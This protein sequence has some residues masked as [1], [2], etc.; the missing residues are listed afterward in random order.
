VDQGK[1][2][3]H[4]SYWWSPDS[5]WLVFNRNGDDRR[6]R[7]WLYNLANKQV[8]AVTDGWYDSY[9]ASFS[10]DGKYLVFVSDRDFNPIYS[11]TEWNHAYADM[12]KIY[13]V[14][15]AKDT[16]S[17][18]QL[19]N[20][21][22]KSVEPKTETGEVEKPE[23]KSG[24]SDTSTDVRIDLD[25]IGGRIIALDVPAGN[26]GNP[27]CINGAVYYSYRSMKTS[28]NA[29]KMFD[30]KDKKESD[31]GNAGYF[32]ISA[33]N[34]K[35]MIGKDKN[36]YVLDLP[37]SKPDLS[38]PVDLS[39][40]KVMVDRHAEWNQ[41]FNESW[42]Q[43]RDFFWDPNMH[44]V[45][46]PAMKEKYK[47][48]VPHVNHRNDLTYI[49]GE[50]IGELNIGH[51]YTGGG[52]APKPERVSV[53][54]LGADIVRDASGYFQVKKILKGE[55]WDRS[56]R[57]PLTEIGVDAKEGDYIIAV[58]GVSTK[59]MKDLYAELV[60]TADKQVELTLNTKPE[61]TGGRKVLVK[62]ISNEANLRYYNW[63]EDNIRKVNEATNGEVGYIHI[64]DMGVTGLNEFTKHFYP[65]LNKK[66][67]IIDDRGNGGGN[68]SPMIIER[69]NRELSMI[70]ISRNNAAQPNPSEMQ[71]GPKVMLI[72]QYSASDGDIFPYR[73]RKYNMGKIIG[74][75]SW[76]GV[77]GIRGSLPF[78]DGGTLSK[79]EFSRYDTEGK[80][81]IMEGHGV[82]PDIVV[83]Q[84]PY[85]EYL[86]NDQQLTRAIE[87]IKDELK[88]NPAELAP[89]PGYPNK[90]K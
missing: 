85:Q 30:L 14:T 76:G 90:S 71:Y 45:D 52:D 37:R 19:V 53:G 10:D 78:V 21:E 73:F 87:F 56:D 81:W 66:A 18:F 65:Q 33:D 49:I 83:D 80:E 13:L 75:R 26:Y 15:L 51:A 27:F 82:D 58:N 36:Y 9:S 35:M 86:G 60:N 24:D 22:V 29:L 6:S 57:S 25:G 48:L 31:L 28:G 7:I 69:L 34:K 11:A 3:E 89:M 88:K 2:G 41:V 43:M 77:V 64:P 84:D 23:A 16:P 59:D 44:G 62:P 72:D 47:V 54:Q 39:N 70:T 55:N 50:M 20:D 40:M 63:V 74:M 38:S 17:P 67:L 32:S 12:S 8:N 42:M 4:G 68:V 46:W 61:T 1:Y 5:K 79:P